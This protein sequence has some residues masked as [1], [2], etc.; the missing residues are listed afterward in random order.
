MSWLGDV[1]AQSETNI[2]PR[3][4]N[5]GWNSSSGTPQTYS[6]RLASLFDIPN[7]SSKSSW[8]FKHL[9]KISHITEFSKVISSFSLGFRHTIHH[10][11]LY[12]KIQSCWNTDKTKISPGCINQWRKEWH[13]TKKS[14]SANREKNMVLCFNSVMKFKILSDIFYHWLLMQVQHFVHDILKRT[15][16]DPS[17]KQKEKYHWKRDQLH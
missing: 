12:E 10:L 2:F 1:R 15:P 8:S 7:L 6:T 4:R 9:H 11:S 3:T 13:I 17:P 16:P 14:R 5:L